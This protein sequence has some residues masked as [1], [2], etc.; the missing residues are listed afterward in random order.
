MTEEAKIVLAI[1]GIVGIVTLLFSL[2]II[3]FAPAVLIIFGMWDAFAYWYPIAM[4]IGRFLYFFGFIIGIVYVLLGNF[5]YLLS[6]VIDLIMAIWGISVL[7]TA[8]LNLGYIQLSGVDLQR[9]ILTI[10]LIEGITVSSALVTKK[11]EG[12]D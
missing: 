3:T 8:V 6:G 5:S 2:V 7:Q 4:F 9:T 10:I 12:K 1:S 11:S